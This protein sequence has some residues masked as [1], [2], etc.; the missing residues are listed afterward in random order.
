MEAAVEYRF[1]AN[2]RERGVDAAIRAALAVDNARLYQ[3]SREVA[4]RRDEVLGIVSHD[5]RNPLNV[6]SMMAA[7]LANN[8]VNPLTGERAIAAEHVKTVL[9][10]MA[11]C[12]M[13]D[14][15]GEWMLRVGLPA[16]S[17]VS[18]GVLAVAGFPASGH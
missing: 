1:D 7:T 10:V 14:F 16:K 4:Q 9:S 18:G 13:Y 5:L 6:V 11:S 3:Q 15:S 12:G 8:G 17:G 2:G